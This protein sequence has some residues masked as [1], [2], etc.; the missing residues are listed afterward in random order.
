M[1]GAGNTIIATYDLRLVGLSVVIAVLASYTALDLAGRITIAQKATHQWIPH[2]WFVGGAI[3]L[4]MGIWSMHFVGMLA[5]HLTVPVTYNLFLVLVSMAVAIAAAGL[6]LF[7]VSRQRLGW[8]ALLA[9]SLFLGLAIA[10]MHYIGMA[11]VRIDA[12]PEYDTKLVALSIGIAIL[13]SLAALWLAFHLRTEPLEGRQGFRWLGGKIGSAILMGTAIAGMHYTAMAAVSF[14]RLVPLEMRQPLRR[15]QGVTPN[16]STTWLAVGIGM[17]TLA[18]LSIALLASLVQQ[19]LSAETAKA[20]VLRQSEERFRALVQHSSDI[21]TIL[22]AD[23]TIRYASPSIKRILGYKPEDLVGQKGWEYVHPEDAPAV[24]VALTQV[25]QQPG[26]VIPVEYRFRHINGSWVYLESIGN[27]LLNDLSIQGVVINSR[28]VSERRQAD[29]ALQDALQRLN[30]HVENSP[31]AIVE[32]DLDFRVSRW[33]G[34][35]ET[36][37]GWTPEDVLGKQPTDWP[38]IVAEDTEIVNSVMTRLR[39]GREQRNVVRNRNYTKDG[40]IVHCEWYNSALL[41]ESGNFVSVLSLVLDV[42][43]AKHREAERQRA[44][45]ALRF[46]AEASAVLTASLNYETTL[47]NLARL[48][49]PCIADWCVVDVISQKQVRRLAVAHQDPSKVALAWEL[50]RRYPDNPNSAE[51]VP[52][53]LRAGRAELVAE[54][55]DAVLVAVAQ[56]ADHLKI[57]RELGLK[58]Y[59]IV[60]LIARGRIL[61]AM[62]FVTAESGRRYGQTDLALAEDLAQRAA[63]AM[64]NA[65]LYQTA[66]ESEARFRRVVESNMI[67][68]IFWDLDGNITEA[69]DAFLEMVGYTRAEL[70]SGHVRWK[71]MTPEEYRLQDERVLAEISATGACPSFEKEYLCKDGSRVPVLL[72][73][74]LLEGFQDRGVC[75]VLDITARKQVEQALRQSEERYRNFIEQSSEGIW[76]FELE[77]PIAITCPEDEQIQ[78]FYEYGYL[79]ECNDAMAQM[80]GFTSAAE[81][82]GAK[83][84]DLL[85]RSDPQNTEYLRAF[86]RSGYRLSDAESHEVDQQGRTKYFLNNLVGTVE[87]GVLIRAWGNQRDITD[88]KQAEEAL[89]SRAAE[90]AHLTAVLTQTNA[91]LEKRNQEL[92]QFAYVTSHDLKAP[93]RAIASLSEWLEDDLSDQLTAETQRQMSLLRSRVHRMEGLINGILQYSRA[94]RVVAELNTVD[95]STLLAEVIDTLSPPPGFIIQVEP[96]MPTFLAEQLPLEQVF[97]NLIS[98]AIKHHHQAQGQ[99]TISV[100]DRGDFYEFAVADDGP[101]IPPQYHEKVF[102]IFQTLEARDTV[103]STGIGLSLVKKIV[104]SK[105]GTIRLESQAGQG[106]TFKFTWPKHPR[107]PLNDGRQHAESPT[108]G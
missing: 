106:A 62:T 5:Y 6:A 56:D 96:G 92:D 108:S 44:E 77:Q 79:A 65:T 90:L 37:F 49:V 97:A 86:I 88:R 100:Q 4:G 2:F 32:W 30:F 82:V 84:D 7:I 104:E 75:F 67:G 101:G 28:D 91:A 38:F 12:I 48:T 95:V 85:V 19:R 89:R 53:V 72:G 102:A 39:E 17:A 25:M 103:E 33:S 41:D 3:A 11:A 98:N 81:L 80:Y 18:I 45:A 64:D 42:T 78:H 20:E 87:D 29:K 36:I 24:Q 22:E 107:T 40:S 27:N 93:L 59:M 68:I 63:L 26:T 43:V 55:P 58:S 23:A 50:A 47:D 99:V 1:I 31:L 73:G 70:L 46:L 16:L 74:A 52:K 94:G 15:V 60:P 83:P 69:N 21:I 14:N 66:Q 9:G 54:I 71:D 57:L 34:E 35:A 51:G 61:G 8:G 10:S 76:R 13:A 105:G